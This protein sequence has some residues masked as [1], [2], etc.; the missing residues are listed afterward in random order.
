MSIKKMIIESLLN[1]LFPH[2]LAFRVPVF[3]A[4][5]DKVAKCDIAHLKEV[6][7]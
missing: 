1:L 6:K 2:Q 7:V 3:Q 4:V 5:G